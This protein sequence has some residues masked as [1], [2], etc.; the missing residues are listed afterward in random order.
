MAKDVCNEY[1]QEIVDE[2]VEGVNNVEKELLS[3]SVFVSV[4]D[5]VQMYEHVAENKNNTQYIEQNVMTV[6]P[7]TINSI[8]ADNID[9]KNKVESVQSDQSDKNV[10]II[11]LS[12]FHTINRFLPKKTFF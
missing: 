1:L 7:I 2:V 11:P 12:K 8:V 3:T 10:V 5:M 4:K 9:D 6:Q